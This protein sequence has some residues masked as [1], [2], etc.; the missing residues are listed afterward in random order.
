[1][2]VC[3]GGVSKCNCYRSMAT[4][5][6]EECVGNGLSVTV[7]AIDLHQSDMDRARHN[8]I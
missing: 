5:I 1:M 2:I 3:G 7:S 8:W 4:A 6:A